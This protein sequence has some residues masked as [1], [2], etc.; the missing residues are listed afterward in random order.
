MEHDIDDA[1]QSFIRCNDI[2]TKNNEPEHGLMKPLFNWMPLDV[3]KKNCHL[4]THCTSTPAYSLMKKK[5]R[6]PFPAFN[7]KRRSEPVATFTVYFNASA[8][9]NG[10]KCN[11]AFVVAK[12][13]VFNV[14]GMKFDK[15]IS[16]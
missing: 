14:Y 4:S 8:I 3:I 5:Y 12:T 16:Q 10:S 2:T 9:D 11:Q 1:I 7:A 13:V 6:S 15:K